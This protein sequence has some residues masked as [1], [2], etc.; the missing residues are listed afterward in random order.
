MLE[1]INKL[2]GPNNY[3]QWKQDMRDLLI[4]L[5]LWP[6]IEAKAT[7]P[8]PPA[9]LKELDDWT[10]T[11]TKVITMLKNR[12]EPEPR[13]LINDVKTA[14]QAWEKLKEY[15]P[16]G[17]VSLNSTFN[18]FESLTLSGCDND[19]RVYVN[20]FY[21]WLLVFDALSTKFQFDENWKIHRFHK[22]LLPVYSSYVET[23][24]QNHN[25]FTN[26]PEPKF[27]L[28]YAIMRFLNS[29]T[30]PSEAIS[31]SAHRLTSVPEEYDS[32][33]IIALVASGK[34]EVRIQKGAHPGN[35]RVIVHAVKYCTHCKK[36]YHDTDS[37]EVL[38]PG[39]RKRPGSNDNDRGSRGRGR[40]R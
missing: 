26:N 18:R 20:R 31:S 27:T 12:C 38:H 3:I 1:H 2:Q 15:K 24:N 4:L 13:A 39:L 17:W 11:Q 5:D 28:N 34:S 22:G 7:R 37:C 9:T 19:P 36:D 23:Y 32:R 16:R 6:Y 8:G 33:A 30:Y 25:A 29:V 40:P 10:R 14:A 35:S 21:E